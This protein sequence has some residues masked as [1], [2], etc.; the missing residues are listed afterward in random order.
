MPANMKRPQAKINI[1]KQSIKPR[2]IEIKEP[3]RNNPTP[4][5]LNPMDDRRTRRR[6]ANEVQRAVRKAKMVAE[7]ARRNPIVLK[8]IDTRPKQRVVGRESKE[9]PNVILASNLEYD[10]YPISNNIG[11][12]ILSYNRKHSLKRCVESILA[13][14]DLTITTVFISD[15]GSDDQSTKAYL[16]ELKAN[17]NIVVIENKSRIGIAGNTNRLLRCLSR[18]KF[19]ILL[20]DDVEVLAHNWE[21]VY[22]QAMIDTGFHHFIFRMSGVYGAKTGPTRV[23][24]NTS[25][26]MVDDKPQGAVLAF[27][28]HMLNKCGYFDE[29]YGLYGMEHVDWSTKSYEQGL[30]PNGYSDIVGSDKYF[31]LHADSSSVEDRQTL[32]R[33]AKQTYERRS[34]QAVLPSDATKVPAVSYIIPFRDTERTESIKTVV[35]NIRAQKYPVIDIHLVEQDAATRIDLSRYDPVSYELVAS[36]N[37]L[38]NKSKAFNMAATRVK[39]DRIIMHDADILAPN[40]YT[41]MISD[42]LDTHEAC[43]IGRTV[44]YADKESTNIINQTGVINTNTKIERMVG[45]YEG[46][47]LAC[48]RASYWRA[49]AFNEDFWGYGC[50]DCDFYARLSATATW[51]EQRTIDFLHLFHGRVPGWEKHH[52]INKKIESDLKSLTIGARVKLQYDQCSRLGYKDYVERALGDRL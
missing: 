42:I 34:G 50:E 45:Y 9:N 3:I 39:T 17:K 49:G 4:S 48:R 10:N 20:N 7:E 29:S 19:G 23:V 8:K 11:V 47:S 46:G 15:D 16:N 2:D 24:N 14:T 44:I 22:P 12:G 40:Y 1:T 43:H 26:T 27:T 30:Q 13:F 18:F 21:Y 33:N 37:S 38:F 6:A 52:E 5:N 31:H 35:N 41:Q 25:I 32:L 51:Y 36:E 28:S